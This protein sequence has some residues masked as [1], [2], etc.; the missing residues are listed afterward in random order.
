VVTVDDEVRDD[1]GPFGIG[2][3]CGMP[4]RNGQAYLH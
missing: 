3:Y 4:S 1:G 2:G